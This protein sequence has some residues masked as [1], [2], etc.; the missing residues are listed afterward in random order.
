M[1][2]K[3][4]FLIFLML[5]NSCE[6]FE[7]K[8]AANEAPPTYKAELIKAKELSKSNPSLA[9]QRL[10]QLLS[11]SSENSLSDDAL[12]LMGDLLY[13]NGNKKDAERSFSRILNSR[14]S[15][16]L[17]GRALLYK[18]KIL[19]DFGDENSA[20]KALNYIDNNSI[21]DSSAI[22]KIESLR[23]P[24]FLKNE[25][26]YKYLKSA[27]NIITRTKDK[28][29]AI[30]TNNQALDVLK[31]KLSGPKSKRVLD[32]HQLKLFHAQAALNL[33]EHYLNNDQA[34]EGI[35]ILETHTAKLQ[36]PAYK[37]KR[38][39][40]ITQGQFF[41]SANH[42]VIG[43]ILPLTGKYKSV[44]NQILTGLQYSFAIWDKNSRT[45]FKL[46]ILDSEGD[47]DQTSLAFDEL[48]RKDKPIAIIGGLVSKTAQVL[49]EKA[50]KL[51]VPTLVLSQKEGLTKKSRYGFQ[52]Y[53]SLE[54]Y[55][56]FLSSIAFKRAGFK[57][58]A[59]LQ[60][61]KAF[62][63]R[64]GKAFKKSF[65]RLGG[66]ITDVI[67][68][69]LEERR[70]LPNAVKKLVKL[71]STGDRAE[72]YKLALKK[73][74]K[75][76]R[77]RGQTGVPKIELVLKPRI[78]FDALFIADGAKNGG[79]IASTLAYFDV[80]DIPLLG[81]H[82]WNDNALIERGQR[83]V[84]GSVFAD[85]YHKAELQASDCGQDFLQKFNFPINTYIYKGLEAGTILNSA[86]QSY[87]IESRRNLLSALMGT[88][89][90]THKCIP[91]GLIREKHN[92]TGSLNLLTVQNKTI[93]PLKVEDIIKKTDE[94][95]KF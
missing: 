75:S 11:S 51:K 83:F 32:D 68:Y 62:S 17:D 89:T 24:I 42:D 71:T 60:S 7:E 50:D 36:S 10:N 47:P 26:Y 19:R 69:D 58:I 25:T 85:S 4:L 66:E 30:K 52:S 9:I 64:Y 53:Q 72:E 40:L 65:E 14:Y 38:D 81:T 90:I 39:E 67:E 16:P 78:D 35:S 63:T 82:L 8:Q 15:S 44:G 70:A 87:H 3:T 93:S 37:S 1:I 13:K 80:E 22:E 5:L 49:L 88:S 91:R 6:T 27:H 29:L 76:S 79:L 46:A 59:I 92:F 45:K 31:I 28:S 57:K 2:Q 55:S 23:A 61:N 12:F 77:S 84:E 20:L 18:T 86:Y 95:P 56:S 54:I 94:S 43:V 33:A 48:I 74:Q 73:W 41:I 21:S 34:E